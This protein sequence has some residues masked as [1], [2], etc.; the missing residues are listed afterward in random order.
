MDV[1]KVTL[2]AKI[3]EGIDIKQ[4]IT[5]IEKRERRG[6]S[7]SLLSKRRNPGYSGLHRRLISSWHALQQN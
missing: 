4:E 2:N 1:E 7:C 3:P 5:K 6:C